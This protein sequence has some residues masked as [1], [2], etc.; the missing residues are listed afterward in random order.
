MRG[1]AAVQRVSL[2]LMVKGICV[3]LFHTD[4]RKCA[5]ACR[6]G[7][8][9][10]MRSHAHTHAYTHA[11]THAH[12]PAC[13]T[14]LCW[15]SLPQGQLNVFS[16]SLHFSTG[17]ELRRHIDDIMHV[18]VNFLGKQIACVCACVCVCVSVH[19]CIIF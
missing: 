2:T 1:Y 16:F 15:L 5:D 8:Q 12:I 11:N 10:N 7:M 18:V 14:V 19:M 6:A 13:M 4:A 9:H 3:Q 17:K